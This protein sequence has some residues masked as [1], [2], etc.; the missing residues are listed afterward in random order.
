[1]KAKIFASKKREDIFGDRKGG[2]LVEKE[3]PINVHKICC[4]RSQGDFQV[5]D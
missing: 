4:I 1:L 2:E 5:Q 3:A